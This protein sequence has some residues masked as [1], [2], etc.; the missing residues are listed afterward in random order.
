[1]K[2]RSLVAVLLLLCLAVTASPPA[3]AAAPGDLLT[4]AEGD[5]RLKLVVANLKTTGLDQVLQGGGPFTLFAPTDDAFASVPE[6]QLTGPLLKQ[7][8]LYQVVP[9]SL[10]AADLSELDSLPTLLGEPLAVTHEGDS[11]KLNSAQVVAA[12]LQASN[13][14]I[15]VI[16]TVLLPEKPQ[17]ADGKDIADTLTGDPKFKT[18][19]GILKETGIDQVLHEAGPFTLF[20]PPDGADWQRVGEAAMQD[21]ASLKDL[22]LHH[23]AV[24]RLT[25]D[26][27]QKLQSTQT[28]SGAPLTISAKGETVTVAEAGVTSSDIEASNGIIHLVDSVLVPP[29]EQNSPPHESSPEKS[30]QQYPTEF[31]LPGDVENFTSPGGNGIANFQTSLTLDELM[32]FYRGAFSERGLTERAGLTVKTDAVISM[33]FDGWPGDKVVV[34][35]VVNLGTAR[36]VN[37]RFEKV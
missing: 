22:L 7:S 4:V 17:A 26:V 6:G 21:T 3:R 37:I 25:S 28:L 32:E 35:Q 1:M 29:N 13:G 11:T 12:D 2:G 14:V 9:G 23:V 5:A 15:H 27:L 30:Q 16:D 33:V 8:L 36:N 19:A 18:L 24:G 20:A 34:L 31:P 10:T